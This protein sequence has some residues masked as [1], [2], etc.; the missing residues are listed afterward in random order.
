[1][2]RPL[3]TWATLLSAP[4][5]SFSAYA[6]ELP[7][8]AEKP[9]YHV[10]FTLSRAD[11]PTPQ[12]N[13]T[14]RAIRLMPEIVRKLTPSDI[15]FPD[16]KPGSITIS[17]SEKKPYCDTKAQFC[18]FKQMEVYKENIR[19]TAFDGSQKTYTANEDLGA[20]FWNESLGN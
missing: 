6:E 8:T 14:E 4:L 5:L 13:L 7:F 11:L 15:D 9:T 10:S 2:R 1:M 12:T 18:W 19:L 20:F 16:T 3:F 17:T